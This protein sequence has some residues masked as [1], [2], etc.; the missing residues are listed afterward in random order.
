MSVRVGKVV[1]SALFN[2]CAGLFQRE[3]GHP[4][5]AEKSIPNDNNKFYLT[6]P[7]MHNKNRLKKARYYKDLKQFVGISFDRDKELSS[8]TNNN[9]I[10][11]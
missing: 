3:K 7:T 6:Y 5:A 2:P 8:L 4:V 9:G 11:Y 10:F 1:G